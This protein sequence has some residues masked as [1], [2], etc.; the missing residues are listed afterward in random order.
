MPILLLIFTIA[1]AFPAAAEPARV[2]L[3]KATDVAGGTASAMARPVDV[4]RTRLLRAMDNLRT[5]IQTLS[6]LHDT[7][8]VLLAWNRER[9]KS[10]LPP[11]TLGSSLCRELAIW[12]PVLSATFGTGRVR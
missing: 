5:D 4:A 8:S 10:G 7:Q 12:C 3:E 1:S 9:L 2:H 6:S 11:A